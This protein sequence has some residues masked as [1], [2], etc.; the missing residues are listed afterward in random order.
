M[1]FNQFILRRPPPSTRGRRMMLS[2]TRTT[3]S[4]SSCA[5]ASPATTLGLSWEKRAPSSATAIP[6]AQALSAARCWSENKCIVSL[7][8]GRPIAR[9]RLRGLPELH[10]DT[11]RA[12]QGSG[13]FRQ[14]SLGLCPSPCDLEFGLSFFA[15]GTKSR[16][17]SSW[18]RLGKSELLL[19]FMLYRTVRP[20]VRSCTGGFT[21]QT[22]AG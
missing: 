4:R 19:V 1:S 2:G 3:A 6:R 16:I 15:A 22:R 18:V 7:S 9:R 11:W 14:R 5:A 21:S 8:V 13:S 12:S 17:N 10:T 20:F